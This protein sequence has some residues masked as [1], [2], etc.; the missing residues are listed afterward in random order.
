MD[1]NTP[2]LGQDQEAIVESRPVAIL[3]A[4][5]GV[6]ASPSLEARKARLLP[7]LEAAEERLVGLVEPRQ[8]VLQHMAVNCLILGERDANG[9]E[10][11]FLLVARDRDVTPL[12]C[13]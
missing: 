6:E 4:G 2:D 12:P 5:E 7:S 9:F 3:L 10:L 1:S 11:G 8:H 13:G